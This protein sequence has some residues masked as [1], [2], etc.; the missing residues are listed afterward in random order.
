[1]RKLSLFFLLFFAIYS[2][3]AINQDKLKRYKLKSGMV[4]YTTTISGK[5]MGSTIIGSGTEKLYFKDWGAL[6]LKEEESTKTTTIKI[7]G[8][9]KTETENTHVINK[10]DNGESYHVDFDKKEIYA[11]RDMAMDMTKAFQPNADAGAVGKNMLESMGGK[12][13]GSG[14]LL[15]YNCE[16]WELSGGKQWM[17]KGVVLKLEM[18]MLGITTITQAKKADFDIAVPDKY[19]DLPDF[20]IQKEEGFMK[21]EEYQNNME[22]MDANIEKLENMSYE[23]WKKLAVKDDEESRNMSDQ[24]LHQTY[25]MIQKMIKAK[26]KN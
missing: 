6:E 8:R 20:P 2:C 19:F 13:V 14:K 16:I 15:G 24:E 5:M 23:E 17:Y 7:F 9:G 18:T 11:G 21:N 10:L 4:E 12:K 22:D 1:M 26:L 25:D 3:N